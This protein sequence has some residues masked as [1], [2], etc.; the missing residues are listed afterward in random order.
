MQLADQE[1]SGHVFL[2]MQ[3]DLVRMMG[4]EEKNGRSGKSVQETDLSILTETEQRILDILKEREQMHIDVINAISGFPNSLNAAALL[5]LEMKDLIC[6]MP[7]RL[8]K[9]K[10]LL[11]TIRLNSRQLNHW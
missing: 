2:K 6:S 8:Y 5:E 1:Q 4:W 7:G 10:Y 11:I 9:L 3:Q